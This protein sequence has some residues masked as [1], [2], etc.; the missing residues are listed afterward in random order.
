MNED[1]ALSN[2]PD[3][4]T[5]VAHVNFVNTQFVQRHD[6]FQCTIFFS[7]NKRTRNVCDTL[8]LKLSQKNIKLRPT[9]KHS[10][11]RKGKRTIRD[12]SLASAQNTDV[13]CQWHAHKHHASY[14][15]NSF[16]PLGRYESDPCGTISNKYESL[17]KHSKPLLCSDFKVTMSIWCLL[18]TATFDEALQPVNHTVA[19]KT[20]IQIY[21]SP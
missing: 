17:L 5:L 8:H 2:S 6:E 13:K 4:N 20:T 16:R 7:E 18:K 11:S 19:E 1:L 15:V 14:R 12:E 9:E 10:S 3:K 21:S